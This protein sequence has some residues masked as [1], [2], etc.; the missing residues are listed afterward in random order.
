VKLDNK[1][2][3]RASLPGDH[4]DVIFWDGDLTGYGLRLRRS[5]D[6][7]RRTFIAQY[8]H[9][10]RTR[11][12]L[13]GTPEKLDASQAREAAKKVLAKVELGQDPQQERADKRLTI[14]HTFRAIVT[15]YLDARKGDVRENSFREIERYLTSGYFRTLHPAGIGSIRRRDVAVCINGIAKSRGKVSAARARAALSA[16]F[17]WCMQQG[18][19]EA[20]PVFGTAKPEEPAARER[21][22]SDAELTAAWKACEDDDFGRIVKLL[23]LTG[24]RRTEIGGMR[25]S[26][27][28]LDAATWTLPKERVKNG[29]AHTLPLHSMVLDIIRSVP[30]QLE[31][32]HLF[33]TWAEVGFTSWLEKDALGERAGITAWTI[34][35][36]R[37]TVATRMADIGIAPHIIE[38]ILNHKSG[39]KAGVAGIYNRSN[40]AREVRAALELWSDHVRALV[41]GAE[42]KIQPL[43]P[44][45]S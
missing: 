39:H 5:G 16:F 34:H 17:V 44:Q 12:Y 32:D 21:V 23:I 8:R 45:V 24:A 38:E 14:S 42:R 11:R 22:L 28:D 2:I 13:I 35:D 41:E 30:E 26:E 25:W 10:G 6:K 27:I 29:K 18:I 19:V 4:N 33:G 15:D 36:I 31:R 7:L 1:S 20:N 3:A 43:Q 37:R 40:Y 9:N